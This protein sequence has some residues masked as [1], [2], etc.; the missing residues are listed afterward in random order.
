MFYTGSSLSA[1]TLEQFLIFPFCWFLLPGFPLS[2]CSVRI[3]LIDFHLMRL[4]GYYCD[5]ITWVILSILFGTSL[6]A[7]LCLQ[8]RRC[9]FNPRVGKIPWRRERLPTPVFWPGEFHGVVH[10]VIKSWTWLSD[11]HFHLYIFDF[12]HNTKCFKKEL[13]ECR[14]KMIARFNFIMKQWKF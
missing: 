3:T 6:V 1:V 12:V 10:G 4:W 14:E 5:Q 7:Q 2:L 9:G 13:K 8:C 11:F